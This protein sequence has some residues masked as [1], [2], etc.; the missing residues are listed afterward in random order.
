MADY[1]VT[2]ASRVRGA[3]QHYEWVVE[4]REPGERPAVASILFNT[5]KEAGDASNMPPE[6]SPSASYV[7]GALAAH[8]TTQ[9]TGAC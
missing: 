5:E 2:K 1:I 4:R 3:E 8:S 9:Q 7:L 6:F